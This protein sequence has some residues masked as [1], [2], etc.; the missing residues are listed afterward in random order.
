MPEPGP[1]GP[2]PAGLVPATAARL[3]GTWVPVT[4]PKGA[5]PGASFVTFQANHHWSGSD[6]CNGGAGRWALGQG[7]SFR[8]TSGPQTAIGCQG[9]PVP[10]WVAGA[11]VA[12]FNG[13]QL[14]LIQPEYEGPLAV[15]RPE[16][17]YRLVR[18]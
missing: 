5:E 16:E 3:V 18:K 15:L 14:V 11:G 17:I 1:A 8:A 9:R 4:L 7:G 13:S 2:L 12:A 6:G 10:G